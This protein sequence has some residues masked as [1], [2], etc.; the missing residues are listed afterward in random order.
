M[1]PIHALTI[2]FLELMH[3]YYASENVSQYNVVML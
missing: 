3:L 2:H 1:E